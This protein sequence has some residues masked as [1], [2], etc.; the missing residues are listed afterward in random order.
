MSGVT[1]VMG[2][3][4]A[5]ALHISNWFN[6]TLKGLIIKY[7]EVPTNQASGDSVQ[8]YGTRADCAMLMHSLCAWSR[9][10]ARSRASPS[11]PPPPP[12][13]SER[14]HAPMLTQISMTS[15]HMQKAI[16]TAFS[17][18][19]TMVDVEVPVGY[20][21]G[22]WQAGI[23]LSCNVYGGSTR[24]INVGSSD[25]HFNSAQPLPP[26][27]PAPAP[28]PA[29]AHAHAHA[30]ADAHADASL[31]L[32]DHFS[33]SAEVFD[34]GWDGAATTWQTRWGRPFTP[35]STDPAEPA[36]VHGAAPPPPGRTFRLDF[37]RDIGR[38]KIPLSNQE[39]AR[40]H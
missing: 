36:S 11:R 17:K 3:R 40:G 35:P 39:S 31:P 1:L 23:G 27:A 2:D 9:A 37:G 12:H 25:M 18:N 16:I 13:N 19:E 26:S 30:H 33:S 6:V 24:F 4:T 22:D 5:T 29:H 15:P 8:P 7:A 28:S 21:L 10:R 14:V 34:A 20:P 38:S 32:P